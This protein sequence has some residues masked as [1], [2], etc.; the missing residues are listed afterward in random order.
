MTHMSA[1]P[2]VVFRCN[3]MFGGLLG[4]GRPS[5]SLSRQGGLCYALARLAPFSRPPA[6]LRLARVWARLAFPRSRLLR[7]PIC[8]V[9]ASRQVPTGGASARPSL[10][11]LPRDSERNA[12]A[13]APQARRRGALDD[14]HSTVP[15]RPGRCAHA[16]GTTTSSLPGTP[17]STARSGKKALSDLYLRVTKHEAY[18]AALSAT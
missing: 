10:P 18:K 15:C 12:R 7:G 4:G 11:S 17:E 8:R 16:P 3:H 14:N 5:S 2:A 1:G 9:R 6:A 13:P